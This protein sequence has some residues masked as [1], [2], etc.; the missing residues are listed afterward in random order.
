MKGIWKTID[1]VIAWIEDLVSGTCLAAIVCIAVASVFG[2]Y[3]LHT[4]FLWAD[5]VNQALLVAVGMFGSARAVRYNGHAEFTSFIAKQKFRGVRVAMRG[6]IMVL[7]IALLVFMLVISYQFT[8]AGTMKTTVLRI[9]RMYMYM[10]IPMGFALCVYEY[11]KV[12]KARV[13]TDTA[14]EE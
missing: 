13:L 5:E 10:S 6:A 3:V 14:A 12:A 7:T 9:P 4:G 11:L 1:T 8:M 2:R